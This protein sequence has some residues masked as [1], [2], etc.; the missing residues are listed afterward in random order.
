MASFVP[1]P[2]ACALVIIAAMSAAGAVHTIW[3]RSPLSAPFR[4]PLDG[5]RLWHGQRIFGDHKTVR[6]FIAMVPA[7]GVAFAG[8]GVLRDVL[9]HWPAAGLWDLSVMQLFWLGCWAGFWFMAGELPNSFLK[10][11]WRI[12]PGSVPAAGRRRVLCLVLDRL[13]SILALLFALSVVVPVAGM[14]WFWVLILGPVVHLG[15]S[16]LLFLVGVK[17]RA[18]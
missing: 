7:A 10:R 14:T 15:F 11:R 6:G 16:G 17:A 2:F 4:I 5:G 3:M 18:A 9:S 13:D 1:E 12:V 8:L